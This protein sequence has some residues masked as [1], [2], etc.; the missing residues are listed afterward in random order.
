M[1]HAGG[2]L[3]GRILS[4]PGDSESL[5]T[6]GHLLPQRWGPRHTAAPSP[7]TVLQLRGLYPKSFE[8]QSSL[9]IF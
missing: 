5:R 3:W 4:D 9:G 8:L 1:F 7:W 2:S 6:R